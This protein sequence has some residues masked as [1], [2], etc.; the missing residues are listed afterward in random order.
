ML[1]GKIESLSVPSPAAAKRRPDHDIPIDSKIG[2]VVRAGPSQ[3]L[4][5]EARLPGP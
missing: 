5:R 3:L 1:I 2:M 4:A